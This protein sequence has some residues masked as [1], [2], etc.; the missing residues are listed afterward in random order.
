MDWCDLFNHILQGY[1]I[2]SGAMIAPSINEVTMKDRGEIVQ[3]Q[4]TTI[5]GH[6]SHSVLYNNTSFWSL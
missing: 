5:E 4:N 6:Q 2:G 1:F 3:Y